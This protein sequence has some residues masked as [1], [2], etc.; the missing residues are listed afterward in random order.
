MSVEWTLEQ[1]IQMIKQDSRH[2]A[3]R[4]LT[5]FNADHEIH[6]FDPREIDEVILFTHQVINKN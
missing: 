6:W 3:K 1:A 5:W 2:Y 4:Q